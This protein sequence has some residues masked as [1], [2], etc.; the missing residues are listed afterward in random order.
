MDGFGNAGAVSAGYVSTEGDEVSVLPLGSG[1]EVGRSCVIASYKGKR[2]MFDC[3][4]HPAKNG[5]D[6]LPLFDQVA[7]NT[8]DVVLI[9]HFH[10][11]H[12]AALPYLIMQTQFAGRVFMT[13]ATKAFYKHVLSDYVR[14]GVS[15]ADVVTREWIDASFERIET[16]EYHQEGT[17]NGI[18]FQPFN[19]GHVLGAAMFLV[20][21]AGVKLLYTGDYSRVPDRHLLAAEVPPVCPDVL[22]VE[23]TYGILVLETR[24]ERE[25]KFINWVTEVVSR[26]GRCLVPVFALGRAQELLLILE[27]HWQNN[28]ELQHIPVYYASSLAS[29][30]MKLYQT[31]V[32]S[33]NDRVKQQQDMTSTNPFAFKF[34]RSLASLDQFDDSGPCVVLA[35]PGM[36]QNGISRD[37]FERWCGDSRNGIIIAGYCVDGTLAKEILRD[38]TAREVPVEDGSGKVLKVRMRTIETVSFSAHSDARQTMDFIRQ[39]RETTHVV[40][41]HGNEDAIAK[42][43][44]KLS[45]DFRHQ[46]NFTVHQSKNGVDIRMPFV[47]QRTAK[48]LASLAASTA[49]EVGGEMQFV[50]GQPV[51]GILLVSKDNKHIIVNAADVQQFTGLDN[52][53]IRQSMILPLPIFKSSTE[54]LAHIQTYFANGELYRGLQAEQT[55]A[56]TT[57]GSGRGGIADVSDEVEDTIVVSATASTTDESGASALGGNNGKSADD[58]AAAAAAAASATSAAEAAT[59][60]A[61]GAGA[62]S[63]AGGSVVLRLRV[64]KQTG[65]TTITVLWQTSRLN[66]LVADVT[67]VALSRLCDD[68]GGGGSGGAEPSAHQRHVTQAFHPLAV[69]G[70]HDGMLGGAG[71][72]LGSGVALPMELGSMDARF[73]HKSFHQMMSQFFTS[74][75]TN[76]VS[77]DCVVETLGGEKVLITECIN[78]R[79]PVPREVTPYAAG[80]I[81]GVTPATFHH[82]G[83]IVKRLYLTLFPIPADFSWCECGA[84]HGGAEDEEFYNQASLQQEAEK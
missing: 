5:L 50:E 39:L 28:K 72:G 24:E 49:V 75:E 70:G 9:T 54:V 27:E 78:I 65:H 37:L 68:A 40:L 10:L 13:S 46:R 67:L 32:H 7:M 83:A 76:L 79:S 59:A 1:G 41:V 60:A 22:I 80:S 47:T 81:N 63:A 19:A 4:V 12:C 2:V 17:C 20:D 35:A 33:M 42:L 23:A 56:P 25:S 53:R 77:G 69:A 73:R 74:C 84:V 82:V 26:G 38:K 44:K 18:R 52:S 66:D 48:V 34:V 11:D 21:I 6:A 36:L 14:T 57:A 16:I 51:N 62:G 31:Y 30:C 61:S 71:A 45:E 55:G 43:Q 58:S 8:I 3:G 15:V 29:R 64:D